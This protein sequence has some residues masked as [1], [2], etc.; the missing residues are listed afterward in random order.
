MSAPANDSH[1]ELVNGIVAGIMSEMSDSFGKS[2]IT[3]YDHI[4]SDLTAIHTSIDCISAHLGGEMTPSVRRT[5]S[6]DN[7][8]NL[9]PSAQSSDDKLKITASSSAKDLLAYS[10][11]QS[12]MN[13]Y[14]EQ[15]IPSLDTHRNELALE[16]M[17]IKVLINSIAARLDI[18]K[19]LDSS[20]SVR[21]IKQAGDGA[22]PKDDAA[23]KDDAKPKAAKPKAD[24]PKAVLNGD[25]SKFAANALLYCA[26][27]W[28]ENAEF[29]ARFITDRIQGDINAQASLTKKPEG[30]VS[31]LRSEGTYVW[32]KWLT[33]EQKNS[34]RG[35]FIRRKEEIKRTDLAAPLTADVDGDV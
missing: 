26:Q 22:V 21:A 13:A 14:R 17:E 4:V 12:V 19:K 11:I 24:K 3:M 30:S 33:D 7:A 23:P 32:N 27:Q 29:R 18:G 20:S 16:L 34:I 2:A 9:F 8:A 35:D 31:R 10:I 25:G 6:A 15:I 5:M 1:V 28:S